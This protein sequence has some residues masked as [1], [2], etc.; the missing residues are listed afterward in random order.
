MRL[1]TIK[2]MKMKERKNK[3]VKP[4]FERKIEEY[5]KMKTEKFGN[6]L[7]DKNLCLSF[8]IPR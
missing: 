1:N 8:I 2:E 3:S 4:K 5:M 7:I 6:F